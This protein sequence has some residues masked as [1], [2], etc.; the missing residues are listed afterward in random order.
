MKHRD[1]VRIVVSASQI[2]NS[3]FELTYKFYNES[4]KLSADVK[5]VHVFVNKNDFAKM[6]IPE[7]IKEKLSSI[8][9]K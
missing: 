8:F 5:T 3:S 1:R 4:D 6:D 9:E 7:G 2:R